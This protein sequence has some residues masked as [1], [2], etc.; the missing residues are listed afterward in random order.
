MTREE[1]GVGELVVL[2][3]GKRPWFGEKFPGLEDL[4]FFGA[5]PTVLTN[6]FLG[7]S[8]GFQ[9]HVEVMKP[10]LTGWITDQELQATR[11]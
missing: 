11:K 2:A 9:H 10:Y 4:D 8:D 5:F 3:G 7:G 1:E 6:W